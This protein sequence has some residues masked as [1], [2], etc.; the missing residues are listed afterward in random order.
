MNEIRLIAL[1]S[2]VAIFTAA[3]GGGGGSGAGTSNDD[4]STEVILSPTTAKQ[5][6]FSEIMVEPA[7]PANLGEWFEV[8]NPGA[9]KINLR[10]CVFTSD[11]GANFIVIDDLIIDSG[12]YKT[13]AISASHDFSADYYYGSPGLSLKRPADTLYLTCNGN[14][15]DIRNNTIALKGISSALS[16]NGNGMWC[17]NLVDRYNV[18]TDTGT[19]GTVNRDCP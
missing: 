7:L 17:N 14:A 6:I 10:D 12:E 18:G 3:C 13:F 9:D 19:P 2:F 15:I 4:P 5:I 16:N 8:Q 11:S 1:V